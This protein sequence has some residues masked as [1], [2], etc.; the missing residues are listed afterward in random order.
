[1][2]WHC[3]DNFNILRNFFAL[4]ISLIANCDHLSSFFILGS[5]LIIGSRPS[6]R[7]WLIMASRP[8]IRGWLIIGSRPTIGRWLI[9][10]A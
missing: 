6:I 2:V 9:I 10:R 3:I 5:W 8:T 4:A 7:G 1:M